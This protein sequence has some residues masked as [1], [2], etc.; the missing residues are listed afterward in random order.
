MTNVTKLTTAKK[1]ALRGK[2][3]K[4]NPIVIIGSS[5]LTENVHKE[6]DR[7]LEDHELIKIR[8]NAEERAQKTQMIAEI[9]EKNSAELIQLIGHIAVL[10]RQ[11]LKPKKAGNKTKKI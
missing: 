6:I 1:C 7:A 10:Y 5:G 9:C 2:A 8:V 3:H 4:L 11:Q